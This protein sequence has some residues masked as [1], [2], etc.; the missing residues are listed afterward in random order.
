MYRAMAKEPPSTLKAL[1]PKRKD[2]SFTNRSPRPRYLA[3]P[4]SRARGVM[5]YWG[6]LLWKNRAL[7]TFPRDMMESCRSSLLGIRLATHLIESLIILT[8]QNFLVSQIF[9]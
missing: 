9:C 7:A 6:K 4:S 5:E 2:S 3:M 1:R 8:I